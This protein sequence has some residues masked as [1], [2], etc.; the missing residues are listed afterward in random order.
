MYGYRPF[1]PSQLYVRYGDF[2][3]GTVRGELNCAGKKYPT[4]GLAELIIEDLPLTVAFDDGWAR[5]S[6]WAK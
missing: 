4:Y 6:S 1:L 3:R 2:S 5:A